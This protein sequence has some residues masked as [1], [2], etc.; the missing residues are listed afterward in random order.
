[1]RF[2]SSFFKTLLVISTSLIIAACGGGGG[3]GGGSSS[4]PFFLTATA[5]SFSVNED[6]TYNGK[7]A[8]STNGTGTITI[9]LGVLPSNGQLTLAG[10]GDFV[11]TPNADFS[12]T[13]SFTFK[14]YSLTETY[15]SDPATVSIT[16]NAINDIPELVFESPPS[17]KDLLFSENGIV[18]ITATVTDN[19]S[20]RDLNTYTATINNISIPVTANKP[21]ASTMPVN[22]D[23]LDF[24]LDVSSIIDAGYF[25]ASIEV[26]DADDACS[27]SMFRSFFTTNNR[28]EDKYKVYNL[29]GSYD[30]YSESRRN[31][32]MLIISDSAEDEAGIDEFRRVM[33]K[34][35][36]LLLNSSATD[37]FEGFFN[38]MIVEPINPDGIS[39]VD[40]TADGDCVDWS[41]DIFCWDNEKLSALEELLFPNIFPD[42]TALIP[43]LD[44]RGVTSYDYGRP[45]TMVQGISDRTHRTFAHELGHAHAYLG[46]EYSS[47]GEREYTTEEITSYTIWDINIGVE[48]DPS[49][50]K[51]KHFIND[52]TMVPGYHSTAG[53]IGT[54]LFEGSYYSEEGSYR[55]QQYSI[56][57]CSRCEDQNPGCYT[58]NFA[59]RNCSDYIDVQ[60]EGFAI[61][62]TENLF[63]SA[64]GDTTAFEEDADSSITGLKM[65]VGIVDGGAL[66]TTKYRVEWYKDNVL[67]ASKNNVM[68][69]IF[70]RPAIDAWVTYTWKVKDITGVVLVPDLLDDPNDCYLGLFDRSTGTFNKVT[71]GVDYQNR[72]FNFNNQ[73]YDSYNYGYTDGC[74]SGTLMI[75]W[76]KYQ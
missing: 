29:M 34:S 43:N 48:S 1:M 8:Y 31:T 73:A 46:D 26:C 13:D 40:L 38:V 56:M 60:A 62:S 27:N 5:L 39:F 63:R 59:E 67:D 71:D 35:I 37:Y 61:A 16:V 57:G 54:G 24:E 22:A 68:E 23:I 9:Q 64:F 55:P 45:P 41:D 66:D 10:S 65:K 4:T 11:Y 12:G 28:I 36:N 17:E 7:V 74:T 18:K 32:D 19:D 75:N 30:V 21:E 33:L 25:P 51:W 14:A 44:G 69:T 47:D 70:D 2:T 76:S 53:Q 72:P 42:V 58:F 20:D 50:T 49:S 6:D 52:L 15:T 3:G